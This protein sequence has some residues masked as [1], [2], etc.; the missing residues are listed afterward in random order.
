MATSGLSQ[1]GR[2]AKTEYESLFQRLLHSLGDLWANLKPTHQGSLAG[3]H[4][5]WHPL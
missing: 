5:D 2:I 1:A 4:T 3:L